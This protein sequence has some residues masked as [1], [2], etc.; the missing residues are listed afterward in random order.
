MYESLLPKTARQAF[1]SSRWRSHLG[2]RTKRLLDRGYSPGTV[3]NRLTEWVRFVQEFEECDL[4]SDY[5]SPEVTAYLDRRCAGMRRQARGQIHVALRLLLEPEEELVLK[6]RPPPVPCT[7]LY[8]KHVPPYFLHTK[9]HRG[10]QLSPQTETLLRDFFDWLGCRGIEDLWDIGPSEVRDFLAEQDH[11]RPS[12]LAQAA[13]K[14]RV[15]L[16][17]LG[18]SG[19][20][21][22]ELATC[23][24]SP[25]LYRMS[26]PPQV[27]DDETITRVLA[28]VDRSTPLGRRNYAMLLLAVWYG[29]RPSDICGLRLDDIR[30]RE[31][32]IVVVQSKTQRPLEL[33]LLTVVE[34]AMV[35]YLKNGRPACSVREL[36]LRHVAPIGPITAGRA[37]L[38]SVLNRAFK[39][40]GVTPSSGPRGSRRA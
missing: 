37:I 12:S 1:Q 34:D 24:E 5:R 10:R 16:R 35:E 14:L 8:P 32:R 28:A 40:V 19:V 26:T 3:R 23:V 39:S 30:W 36:F 9:Q 17:F 6:D 2:D 18:M 27:L 38:W 7:A 20:A 21:S 4:P 31:Q 29:M 11:L 13:S 25:R 33:P 22:S 15:F